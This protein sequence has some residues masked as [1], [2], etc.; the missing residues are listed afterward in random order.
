M[1]LEPRNYR[2]R[3]STAG[4]TGGTPAAGGYGGT[5]GTTELVLPQ[6]VARVTL[7][8]RTSGE[9]F[10]TVNVD[11]QTLENA[12]NVDLTRFLT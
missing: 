3:H 6:L 5:P 9:C 12:P 11:Q 4:D 10:F 2:D 1:G 7:L 8:S